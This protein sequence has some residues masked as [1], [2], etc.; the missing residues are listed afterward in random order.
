M[1]L[2]KWGSDQG[3][4]LHPQIQGGQW[5]PKILSERGPWTRGRSYCAHTRCLFRGAFSGQPWGG[6]TV[7]GSTLVLDQEGQSFFISTQN[8]SS[9]PH[10]KF[11]SRVWIVRTQWPRGDRGDPRK[12]HGGQSAASAPPG[13]AEPLILCSSRR[14]WPLGEGSGDG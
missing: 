6:E 5:P 12:E 1:R 4:L 13:G 11:A 2:K 3:N 10:P 7:T 8:P 14:R 9:Q